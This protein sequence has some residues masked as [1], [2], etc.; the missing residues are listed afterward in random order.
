MASTLAGNADALDVRPLSDHIGAQIV[1]FDVKRIGRD[2]PL[3]TI[4]TLLYRY[5]LLCFRD[6]QLAPADLV[7]FTRWFGRPDPHVLQQ[8]TLPGHPEIFVISNIVENGRPLGST[9]DGF[10][11]HT[12]LTYLP[13][14]AALTILYGIEVPPEG[15]D[16]WFASMDRTWQALDEA[17]KAKLRGL[18]GIYSYLKLY[19][20]RTNAP[21]LTPEQRARTPDVVHP[22]VRMHPHTGRET[23]YINKDDCIGVEGYTPEEGVALVERLF[24]TTVAN[25]AYVHKWQPRDLLVWD[26]RGAL[27]SATPYDMEKHRRLV[28]RTSVQGEKP[29]PV[30][31]G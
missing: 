28:Y 23:M 20:K 25:H 5:Q 16:T 11:W 15:A 3:S 30:D 29:I 21:P 10:G 19:G 24:A 1:G 22:L 17:E 31:Q 2:V 18:R 4:E 13:L 12:D 14:P 8:F 6:Q 7:A 26:N 9:M 27:H